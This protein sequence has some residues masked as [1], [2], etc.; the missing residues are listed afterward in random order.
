MFAHWIRVSMNGGPMINIKYNERFAIIICQYI[1]IRRACERWD[2]VSVLP[3][4]FLAACLCVCALHKCVP[5]STCHFRLLYC[6]WHIGTMI[7]VPCNMYTTN[8]NDFQQIL[9]SFNVRIWWQYITLDGHA[10]DPIHHSNNTLHVRFSVCGWA[11]EP[12]KCCSYQFIIHTWSTLFEQH[13][14]WIQVFPFSAQQEREKK[15]CSFWVNDNEIMRNIQW[16]KVF[17]PDAIKQLK[18]FFSHWIGWKRSSVILTL[19]PS[20]KQQS[21]HLPPKKKLWKEVKK[22]QYESFVEFLN[23]FFIFCHFR[24]FP[25]IIRILN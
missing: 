22:T 5:L 15:S 9:R 6:I 17:F 1:S 14:K 7:I 11:F 24:I 13:R 4:E 20:M 8:M 16:P 25:F 10:R 18:Y 23:F 2:T 21:L 19:L 12:L 3:V